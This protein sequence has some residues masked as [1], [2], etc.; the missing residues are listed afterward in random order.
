MPESKAIENSI[1]NIKSIDD[2]NAVAIEIFHYQY[3]NNQIY[4]KYVDFR[5]I[6]IS[7]I[8][9]YSS[10]PFLPIEFFKEH[11]VVS[12][13]FV[14]EVVFT[15]SGTTGTTT[16]R[17]LVVDLSL[18]EK[19]FTLGFNQF[20]GLASDYIIIALLPSYLERG[21]SSLIYMSEK[22][23]AD[24]DNDGSGFY[25][26]DYE[27]L[28]EVLLTHK[29]S[30]KK[31]LL[32]GVTY[33]LLDLAEEYQIDYPELIIMETGGM[34]G[35]R[36]EMVREELHNTLKSAFGVSS[37]YSEYGMTELMS[38]AYS[39]GDGI[40][41]SPPWMKILIRDVNDPISILPDNSSGGINV[42]DLANIHSCSF[43]A[44]Q[45][46]GR[47]YSNGSFEILGR[48]DNSDIRGCNLLLG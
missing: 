45:D 48:F 29:Q 3:K 13:E 4:R 2:F 42:I 24:S 43:I 23:I 47:A 37:I 33:A 41:N 26:D 21:G 1:F 12:G 40:F 35:R 11:K 44:T 27:S 15:S 9:H 7:T 39:T 10:I 34:K 25:L 16:S 17:H 18:Y 14:P 5:N 31:V 22:L 8:Q 46:L 6:D 38:Q 30:K 28:N 19:S 32:L 36:R 20:F